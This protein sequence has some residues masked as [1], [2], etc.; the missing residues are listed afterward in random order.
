MTVE[1]KPVNVPEQFEFLRARAH[2]HGRSF[3]AFRVFQGMTHGGLMTITDL[4]QYIDVL[5]GELRRA[6]TEP[7]TQP[8]RVVGGWHSVAVI[9]EVGHSYGV[10]RNEDGLLVV[11]SKRADKAEWAHGIKPKGDCWLT[12]LGG[13]TRWSVTYEPLPDRPAGS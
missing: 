4:L 1:Q 8:V 11:A 5:E 7:T 9:G 12:I 6:T 13:N 10:A 2:E 3:Q